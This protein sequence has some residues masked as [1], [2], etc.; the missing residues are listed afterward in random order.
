MIEL[1]LVIVVL[2]VLAATVIFALK[3]VPGEAASAACNSDAK[4]AEVAVQAYIASPDNPTH[5][6]P[7]TMANLYN[8]PFGDSF[9]TKQSNTAYTLYLGG[10]LAAAGVTPSPAAV[11]SDGVYVQNGSSGTA[12]L[13]SDPSAAGTNE[14]TNVT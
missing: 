5:A 14:C 4:T 10:D 9:L 1:L 12:F 2:G 8:A 11:V 3:S 13:Y 7:T 6:I